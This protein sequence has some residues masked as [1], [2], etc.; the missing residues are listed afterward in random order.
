MKKHILVLLMVLLCLVPAAAEETAE[1]QLVQRSPLLDAAFSMLEAGNPFLEFY[2]QATG[3][4]IEPYFEDGLPYFFG[5]KPDFTF[6]GITYMFYKYP[7]YAK[8]NAWENSGFYVKGRHY[9]YGLDC[10]GYTNWIFSEVGWPAHD[11]LAHLLDKYGLYGDKY[12]YS[13]HH[14]PQM[15]PYGEL[16]QNLQVGDLLVHRKGSHH[17]M[18]YIGTLRDFGFTAE[19][20]PELADY[21]DHALVIHCG[22]HPDYYHRVTKW[23]EE[24]SDDPYYDDVYPT[25]GGVSVSLVGVV[26]TKA[27]HHERVEY[28]DYYWFDLNGYKLTTWE[29]EDATS[30]CWIR[31]HETK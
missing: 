29:R 19:T 18:M 17:I 6:H 28:V 12:L 25:Y 10:S 26:P 20:A 16:A 15:P 1:V 11:S 7:D 27:P 21:L 14:G 31:L 13:M 4:N 22:R 9:L 3:A 30:W 23:L 2:N 24:H 5:G 8:R